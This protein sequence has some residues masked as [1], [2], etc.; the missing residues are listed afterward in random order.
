MSKRNRRRDYINIQ[1]K[2]I[3]E[4][5][6][7][8]I[9]MQIPFYPDLK[10]TNQQLAQKLGVNERTIRRH[11]KNISSRMWQ[12]IESETIWDKWHKLYD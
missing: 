4:L 10:L 7:N 11:K 5:R 9:H 12:K 3:K 1:R 6:E 8:H 2:L